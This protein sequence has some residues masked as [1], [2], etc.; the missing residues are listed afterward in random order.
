MIVQKELSEP[1]VDELIDEKIKGLG[2]IGEAP[3]DNETYARVNATWINVSNS[4]VP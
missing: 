3:Q 4:L 1:W 2:F